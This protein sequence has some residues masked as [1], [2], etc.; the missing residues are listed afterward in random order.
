MP[1]F[2]ILTRYVT[3]DDEKKGV[4]QHAVLV[5]VKQI[6]LVTTETTTEK[7]DPL[8]GDY[9]KLEPPEQYTVVHTSR[10]QTEVKETPEEIIKL[11]K[12]MDQKTY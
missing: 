3:E 10:G 7:Y 5:K 8:K 4:L 2:L 11:L 12:L 6:T 9:M 1:K